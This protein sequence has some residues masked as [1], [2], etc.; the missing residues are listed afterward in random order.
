MGA[1]LFLSAQFLRIDMWK[2]EK[3]TAVVV[4]GGGAS[5]MIAAIAAA[6]AGAVVTLLERNDRLGK[7]LLATGNGRCNLGNRNFQHHD[8]T[9]QN[10]EKEDFARLAY[11]MLPLAE[12]LEFLQDLGIYHREESSG[13]LYPYSEQAASVLD[14]LRMELEHASVKVVTDAKVDQIRKEH[15]KSGAERFL[16]RDGQ[17]RTFQAARLI[18]ATG[19][20]AGPQY[21]SLGD[22]YLLATS[23]GHSLVSPKPI[24][25]QMTSDRTF[26][27]QLKGVRS[28]AKVSL[29]KSE[30]DTGENR[31]SVITREEGE[32]QFTE[33]GLSGICIFDLSRA[34]QHQIQQAEE[35][36]ADKKRLPQ[37]SV[38]HS[39][40]LVSI[41]FMPELSLEKL[42]QMLSNRS[43]E[44]GHRTIEY[45]LQGL[46]N[47]KLVPV[48]LRECGIA[49]QQQVQAITGAQLSKLSAILKDWRIPV[50]GTRSWED[51]QV[52]AGGI[53]VTEVRGDTMESRKIPGLYLAGELLDLDGKCGGY[54]LQWAWTSGILAGRNAA[55]V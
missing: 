46:L 9:D 7:K 39:R 51:A 2:L 27:P 29:L 22:G 19:G 18:L 24:L 48:L 28:K 3:Q 38:S 40:Y 55:R 31:V 1:P 20:M 15:S 33:T 30:R 5:G 36:H 49:V 34:M 16:V 45:F 17:G 53:P 43:R 35:V 26:F 32:V 42:E 11:D 37:K 21:G 25:V 4:V 23:F 13:R 12:N 14:S 50:T 47:K 8:L 10:P 52:T 54:N 6:R 44:L 41:D